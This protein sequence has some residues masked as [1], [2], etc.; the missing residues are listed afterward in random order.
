MTVRKSLNVFSWQRK[1]FRFRRS[2]EAS[3]DRRF[4]SQSWA[5]LPTLR[6]QIRVRVLPGLPH[7]WPSILYRLILL[8]GSSKKLY[9]A[10]DPLGRRSLLIHKPTSTKPIFL[11]ASVSTGDNDAYEFEELSTDGIFVLD[12]DTLHR[13][14]NVC[15]PDLFPPEPDGANVTAVCD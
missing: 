10:R 5:H 13:P 1:R 6:N 3:R 7:G 9:F 15:V 11:L 12:L 14:E 4:F 8:Q 2:S